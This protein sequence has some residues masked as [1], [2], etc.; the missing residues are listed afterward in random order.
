M[1]QSGRRTLDQVHHHAAFTRA[2][3]TT[4][5]R[6]MGSVVQ[7]C[8]VKRRP[9]R[10]GRPA[11]RRVQP[12]TDSVYSLHPMTRERSAL[13]THGA[14]LSHRRR[15]AQS[16]TAPISVTDGA[17]L[18]HRRSRDQSQTAPISVTDGA[19]LSH[20]RR[21]AQSQTAPSSVTDGAELSHKRRRSQSQTARVD[22]P[23][24][25]EG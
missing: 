22:P 8:R 13:C 4:V 23:C 7:L 21:R 5:T 24:Q 17:E 11:S 10:T 16:Q 25:G 2:C 3:D 6:S 9:V 18:S 15:R 1:S 20:K 12:E 19:E 14:E